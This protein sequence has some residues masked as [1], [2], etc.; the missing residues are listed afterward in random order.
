M[1]PHVEPSRL[2]RII[3]ACCSLYLLIVLAAWLLLYAGDLWWP[4]T[5]LLFSPRWVLAIPLIPLAVAAACWRRRS[6]IAVL[7]TL[8]LVLGPV[9]GFQIPWRAALSSP[10]PGTRVRVLTCNMH[11]QK[12]L[13]SAWE[14]LLAET[15]PHIVAVQELTQGKIDYFSGG[16]WHVHEEEGL[17][18][19]SR[20]PIRRDVALGDDSY[21]GPGKLMRYEVETPAGV[22]VLFS[23]HFAS[24]R[25]GL[26]DTT[27]D[28]EAGF[29]ELVENSEVRWEQ[30]KDLVRLLD[31]ETRP[32]LVVG[33]FNTPTESALFRRVWGRYTDSFLAAGWGWGYTFLGK[34]TT[35]RIDHILSGPGW[36]CERCWVGPY[37]GSPHHPVL[38]DLILMQSG[39]E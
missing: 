24:P 27:E 35:V 10:P 3:A 29:V 15:D 23:L 21:K 22:V 19:A 4:A 2:S 11:A 12:P 20:Y 31:K 38:A 1:E 26:K 32:V 14:R 7:L 17:F 37:V 13:Q 25:E 39:Q 36:H 8:L 33:D 9:M 6:L 34:S 5:Y 16:Q 30:S 28:P 18:L